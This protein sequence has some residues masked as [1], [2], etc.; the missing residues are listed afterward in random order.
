[1]QNNNVANSLPVSGKIP[2]R[3]GICYQSL[4]LWEVV[5][6]VEWVKPALFPYMPS[7]NFVEAKISH[8]GNRGLSI[9]IQKCS[10]CGQP[11]FSS[12]PSTG[13]ISRKD[14]CEIHESAHPIHQQLAQHRTIQQ[15]LVVEDDPTLAILEAEILKAHGYTV[16]TVDSGELA[17]TTLHHS[18]PDLIVLDL[19]LTGQMNGWD[20]LQSLRRATASTP[21]LLTTSLTTTV[22]KYIRSQ[23]ETR[24]TLDHLPKPYPMQILLKRVKRMLMLA[25]Q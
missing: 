5:K 9:L 12:I 1:M 21:V 3:D 19:E 11:F 4:L 25:P 17:M 7:E 16:V 2:L 20:V 8:A 13:W 23:G 14:S 24:L 10:A 22:R 15:I 6:Q 18:M